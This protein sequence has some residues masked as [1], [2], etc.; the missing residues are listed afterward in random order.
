M[1]QP[2]ER[3]TRRI[4]GSSFI[5]GITS[6]WVATGGVVLFLLATGGAFALFNKPGTSAQMPS[7]STSVIASATA[8]HTPAFITTIST[9]AAATVGLQ[10]AIVPQEMP[11]TFVQAQLVK[12]L[13]GSTLQVLINGHE[14]EVTLS[15]ISTPALMP[16]LTCYGREAADYTEKWLDLSGRRVWLEK[17]A[18]DTD[19]AGRL[20]RYVWLPLSGSKRMLNELLVTDGYARAVVTQLAARYADLFLTVEHDA[21]N[22]KRGLWGACGSFSVPLSTEEPPS[23]PSAT[24]ASPTATQQLQLTLTASPLPRPNSPTSPIQTHIPSTHTQ[25]SPTAVRPIST[26]TKLSST[27]TR[28]AK[29]PTPTPLLVATP[30]NSPTNVKAEKPLPTF[31]QPTATTS[32]PIL[33]APTVISLLPLATATTAIAPTE[34]LPSPT[35]GLRYDPN[36]PDRDCADFATQEEAQDFFIA[37]GGPEKDPHRLDHDHDGIACESLPHR[38]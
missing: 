20:L 2:S 9:Q 22:E 15:G 27:P 5:A 26:L 37:A 6:R 32:S 18:I 23:S 21:R 4:S 1:P 12:V 25:V 11:S 30:Q 34:A 3:L 31:V 19:S 38:K 36:G 14:A 24:I 28:I 7:K 10:T 16:Q 13:D 29:L 35:I 33:I 8:L 17:G